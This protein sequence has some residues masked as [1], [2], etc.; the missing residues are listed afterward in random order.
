M[1]VGGEGQDKAITNEIVQ[2]SGVGINVGSRSPGLEKIREGVEKVLADD[3][4]K[5]KA[6]AMSKNFERYDVGTV[7]DDVIQGVVRVWA[8]KQN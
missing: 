2:W 1:V 5:Q 7:V 8:T 3:S 4:Y 6:K